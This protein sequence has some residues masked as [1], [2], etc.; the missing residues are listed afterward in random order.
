MNNYNKHSFFSKKIVMIGF[1]SVG[2]A[3]LPLLF[4]HIKLEPSQIIILTKNDNG[5]EIAQEFNLSLKIA[6]INKENYAH[7]VGDLLNEGDFLL[8]LSVDVASVDLIKLCQERGAL[9]LDASTEPWKGGYTDS[10]LSP[11]LRS[12]YALRAEVLKLKTKK[13]P[14][15]VITHG[16]NPGLV[17]HFVKKAL[18]NMAGDMKLS[19]QPPENAVEWAALAKLLNIRA[20]HIAEHDTQVTERVKL[21]GEFVNTWSV[22]GFIA[23]GGQPAELSW[24]TH[25]RYWPDDAHHHSFGSHSAIYL[26]RPGASTKVRS[27]TPDLGSYHGYLITHA[28]SISIGHYLTLN[29][30]DLYRP[31]VHYAYLPCPDATL[32]LHEFQGNEWYEQEK[33]RLLFTEILD[34]KDE[35]GVLLMGNKKGAYWYGSQLSIHEARKMAPHNNATSLQVAA[36]ILG[37]I[38]WALQNSEASIVEPEEMDYQMV[39]GVALPY[40]GQVVGCYTDWTPLKNRERLFKEKLDLDDPWQFL[41]IRV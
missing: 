19:L 5:A 1:G 31:T 33:K 18:W 34:G 4:R 36:G 6:T 22:D 28:E 40:L 16:A 23:E 24:G 10:A 25:E 26:N 32:S 12:N 2:Q 14:T 11:S 17:S 9:Y 13:S 29:G 37:G 30:E 8:N 35:L 39:L 20:I 38:L 41:N 27:W 21:P 15:A 3:V 7:I